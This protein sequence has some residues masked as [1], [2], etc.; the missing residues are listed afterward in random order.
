GPVAL[1]P[2]GETEEVAEAVEAHARALSRLGGKV[3]RAV[4]AS[5]SSGRAGWGCGLADVATQP[6]PLGPA[7]SKAARAGRCIA[8]IPIAKGRHIE[9]H[10]L[11]HS[12]LRHGQEGAPVA[13]GAGH[14]LPLP[15]L[16]EG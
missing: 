14:R 13:G 6:S 12:Q 10:G 7:L 15:R 5:T 16:Q 11:R 4:A 3:H 9:H 8:W 1:A 2:G